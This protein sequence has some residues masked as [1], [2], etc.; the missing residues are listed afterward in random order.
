[1]AYISALRKRSQCCL[2][3]KKAGSV[4]HKK[5]SILLVECFLLFFVFLNY[6]AEQVIQEQ[7]GQAVSARQA[8]QIQEE[9]AKVQGAEEAAVQETE[10]EETQE[11]VGESADLAQKSADKKSAESQEQSLENENISVVP[12]NM[13]EQIGKENTAAPSISALKVKTKTQSTGESTKAGFIRVLIT[14]DSAGTAYHSSVRIKPLVNS[15][16]SL[17]KTSKK[18][19]VTQKVKK[20]KKGKKYTF[21]KSSFLLKTGT[22]VI[23]PEKDGKVELNSITRSCGNPSYRGTLELKK[24]KQGILVINELP[25]EEY[26]YAVVPSEM[27]VEYG[28]EALKVQAVCARCYAYS[29][30]GSNGMKEY[31]AD[32]NDTTSYQVYNNFAETE[33][34]V[35]AVKETAGNILYTEDSKLVTAY[36]YS[37][38][39]GY[40]ADASEVWGGGDSYLTGKPQ[41]VSKKERKK[42]LDLSDENVFRDFLLKETRPTFDSRFAWYR[43]S[44]VMSLDAME[45]SIK[46]H[47]PERVGSSRVFVVSKKGKETEAD[48]EINIGKLKSCTVRARSHTGMALCIEMKGSKATVRVY[49]EYNIR[50]VLSPEQTKLKRQDGSVLTNLSMM[51][52]SYLSMTKTK[53]GYKIIG[54]GYGHGVGMS[55]NGVKEM[56]DLG[57]SW[58]KI[59]QHYYPGTHLSKVH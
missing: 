23:T 52:S 59:L 38:S 48:S 19:I 39:S 5:I 51:P 25:L 36:Y 57:Y 12:D 7:S 10:Q 2:L 15:T 28:K 34:T 56:S 4:L 58:K 45:A 54:G 35:S 18:K 49:G 50:Y 21:K 47:L 44:M 1:M 8:A 32:V 24:T 53:K 55:Q 9:A 37:T 14:A 41:F 20:L 46:K 16:L 26:L 22:L 11:T 6:T 42:S 27:P 3:C 33:E 17:V 13:L 31:G 30:L 29:Q 40:T 43:W